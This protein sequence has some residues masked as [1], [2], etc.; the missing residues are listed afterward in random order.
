MQILRGKRPII[1]LGKRAWKN[2]NIKMD[3]M[4]YPRGVVS[5]VLRPRGVEFTAP[6]N[7]ETVVDEGSAFVPRLAHGIMLLLQHGLE[8]RS[9]LFYL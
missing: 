9:G 2:Q 6:I 5:L 1:T 4:I 3:C 8:M 7:S